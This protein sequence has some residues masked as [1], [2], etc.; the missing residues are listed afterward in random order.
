MDDHFKKWEEVFSV[1]DKPASIY[2]HQLDE[3]NKVNDN[4]DIFVDY[5]GVTFSGIVTTPKWI[6]DY[7]LCNSM[8]D[9]G[10]YCHHELILPN[11]SKQTIVEAIRI[12]IERD[13]LRR[14]FIPSDEDD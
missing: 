5:N 13:E 12:L 8:E 10:Y 1:N 9:V 11:L 3:I 4:V 2:S 7:L 6:E 14:A